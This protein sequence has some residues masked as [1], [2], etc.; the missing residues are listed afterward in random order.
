MDA[1]PPYPGNPQLGW[2]AP[3]LNIQRLCWVREP[4]G[5]WPGLS[6][7]EKGL[8]GPVPNTLI[9]PGLLP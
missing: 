8:P 4:V 9:I 2:N 1:T 7:G 5:T 3:G 6:E